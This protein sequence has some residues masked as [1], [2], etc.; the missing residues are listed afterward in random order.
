VKSYMTRR[1]ESERSI[2]RRAMPVPQT[3][4]LSCRYNLDFGLTRIL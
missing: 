3:Q 1:T 2:K 4:T